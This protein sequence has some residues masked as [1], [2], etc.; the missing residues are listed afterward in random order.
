[1]SQLQLRK[2]PLYSWSI[3]EGWSSDCDGNNFH[4]VE[5][6]ADSDNLVL[7]YMKANYNI[8]ELEDNGDMDSFVFE[9]TTIYDS[10]GEEVKEIP[11]ESDSE[12]F[13]FINDYVTATKDPNPLSKKDLAYLKSGKYH[14]RVV[15]LTE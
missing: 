6:I 9:T 15:D 3:N 7:E 10:D 14:T 8:N 5:L 13:N 11:E 12:D 4:I 1:M 2:V